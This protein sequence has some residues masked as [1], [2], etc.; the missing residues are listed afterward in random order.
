[1][2]LKVIPKVNSMYESNPRNCANQIDTN[3]PKVS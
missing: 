2:T 1:M 3:L